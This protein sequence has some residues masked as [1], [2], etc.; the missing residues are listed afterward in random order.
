MT[1]IKGNQIQDGSIAADKL[2]FVVP[3]VGNSTFVKAFRPNFLN[4]TIGNIVLTGYNVTNDQLNEFDESEGVF[5]ANQAGIYIISSCT[6]FVFQQ[7]P[8]FLVVEIQTDISGSWQV[9]PGG[10]ALPEI[11]RVGTPQSANVTAIQSLSAGQRL[12]I[13][14]GKGTEAVCTI[15]SDLSIIRH[16]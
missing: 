8:P 12:R 10:I 7:T 16:K 1:K 2:D 5:T 9:L 3:G 6:I 14:I 4:S 13:L 11:N 15:N